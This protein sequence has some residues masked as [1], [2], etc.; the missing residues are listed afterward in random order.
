MTEE[1][2]TNA[3]NSNYV[4]QERAAVITYYLVMGE[5]LT[6]K[7]I[8]DITCLKRRGALYLMARLCRVLPIYL[9]D[10]YRWRVCK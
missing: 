10:D 9:D 8:A 4:P 1:Q 2:I 7:E 3:S 5:A 6:T